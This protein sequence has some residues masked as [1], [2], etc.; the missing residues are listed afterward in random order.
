LK[1]N[2]GEISLLDLMNTI[3]VNRV[4][5]H[6]PMIYGDLTNELME[7]ASWLGLNILDIIPYKPYMQTYK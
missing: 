4:D 5:H 6:Y 7:F 3:I 2:G 1:V